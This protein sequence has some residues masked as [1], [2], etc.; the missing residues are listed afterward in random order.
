[1]TTAAEEGAQERN[2]KW[3]QDLLPFMTRTI[4]LLALFFFI[5]TLFQLIYLQVTIS[6]APEFNV[7][8][9][10]SYL[11]PD[12][13]LNANQL[14]ALTRLKSLVLLENTSMA[15]QYHQANVLLM[16]RT[17]IS[18]IGFITGMILAVTG[19]VFILG[20]MREPQSA[21]DAAA[22][23]NKLSFKSA[24]PGLTLC[25]L[26]TVLMLTTIIVHH[27][28]D[29]KHVAIYIRDNPLQNAQ[30]DVPELS[31]PFEKDT[32]IHTIP[33]IAR[34]DT[35]KVNKMDN[36][37]RPPLLTKPAQPATKIIDTVTPK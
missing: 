17:W 29:V 4:V 1:M 35:G 5:A 24:S 28:I 19:T 16:S 9:S 36:S 37:V 32:S 26:G 2:S 14:I 34:P 33:R 13:S 7:K 27:E 22:G 20:K 11:K 30:E 3:Q 21:L 6:K 8:E 12:S 10:F 23:V 15:N 31:M 25:V 18:Y